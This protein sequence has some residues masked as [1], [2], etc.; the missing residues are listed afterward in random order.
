VD[1]LNRVD[2]ADPKTFEPVFAL[3][4][5]DANAADRKGLSGYHA[6]GVTIDG[7]SVV[8]LLEPLQIT[9]DRARV[10]LAA[11]VDVSEVRLTKSDGSSAVDSDRVPIQTVTVSLVAD[12]STDVA[13]RVDRVAGREGSPACE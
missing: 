1:A 10:E 8:K 4:T 7:E 5:G 9:N 12:R 3:T 11:C 2:L 13:Y 6:D